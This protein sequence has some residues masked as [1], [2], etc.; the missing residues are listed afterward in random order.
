MNRYIRIYYYV[1]ILGF[2][3]SAILHLFFAQEISSNALWSYSSGWQIELGLWNIFIIAF[4]LRI[5]YLKDSRIA[6]AA[7]GPLLLLFSLLGANHLSVV[8]QSGIESSQVLANWAGLAINLIG[9]VAGIVV[10][11]LL[12]RE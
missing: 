3:G 9:L 1:L 4:I 11:M 6:R 7:I 12:K 8:L 5:L 10:L 2:L